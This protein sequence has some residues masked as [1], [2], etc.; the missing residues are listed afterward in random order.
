MAEREE[1]QLEQPSKEV[2]EE[3][4]SLLDQLLSKI[5]TTPPVQEERDQLG[6]AVG[7]LLDAVSKSVEKPERVDG[8][9]IDAYIAQLD[10]RLSAQLDEVLHNEEF[11]EI[12]SAWRGLQFLV[13]RA[14]FQSNIKIEMLNISKEELAEDFEEVGDPLEGGLFTHIYSQAYDQYGADPVTAIVANYDFNSGPMDIDLLRNIADV[15]AAAHCPFVASINP[16]FFGRNTFE[17]VASVP[18]LEAIMDSPAFLNWNSFRDS[19]NSRYV[20]L[21]LPQ[22][23]LRLPYGEDTVKVKNFNYNEDVKAEDHDKYLWGN[24]AF[25]LASQINKSFAEYG[26]PVNIIGPQS[27]G[28]VENLPLHTYEVGEGMQDYKIPLEIKIPDMKERDFAEHG[29]IPLLVHEGRKVEAAFFSAYSAQR[30]QEYDDPVANANSRLS[31]RLP[32][33]LLA[34]RL[35]HYLRVIQRDEIGRMLNAGDV[36]SALNKWLNQ[37]VSGPNPRSEQLKAQRPLQSARVDVQE[38]PDKPGVFDVQIFA[39]PHYQAEEF[40]IE[41]S[42]VAEMPEARQ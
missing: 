8:K 38:S 40:N 25:A 36:Q 14:N 16:Q 28:L 18:Q 35:T 10:S 31:S 30:P 27:G 21:T 37:Y 19:E 3:E 12:E 6:I 13:D 23:L 39:T 32:Y 9:L 41:L 15:A 2:E 7:H 42:L 4:A 20:G 33:V 34:S 1:E 17:E 29:F 26:W 5:D 22:F 24:S 11:Q